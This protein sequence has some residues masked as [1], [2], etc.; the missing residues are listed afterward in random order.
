MGAPRV[1]AEEAAKY[2]PCASESAV[3]SDGLDAVV[4]AC[5]IVAADAMTSACQPQPWRDRQL[6]ETDQ[7]CEKPGHA[8]DSK[9]P[10]S[11]HKLE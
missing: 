10:F 1:A 4:A 7:F 11:K 6:I 9:F 2:E 5:R 3:D 8:A